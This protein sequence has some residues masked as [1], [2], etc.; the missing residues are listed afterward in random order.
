MPRKRFDSFSFPRAF[1][2]SPRFLAASGRRALRARKV[3]NRL[4]LSS[5]RLG[6]SPRVSNQRLFPS[7]VRALPPSLR[8]DERTRLIPT[9]SLRFSFTRQS[10]QNFQSP[11]RSTSCYVC[12][13]TIKD[14]T[15][16]LLEAFPKLVNSS[17]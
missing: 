9:A 17:M 5:F 13:G 7:I 15:M 1:P 14:Y 10:F 16:L 6:S 2:S 11:R 3:S 8:G 12:K 4:Q